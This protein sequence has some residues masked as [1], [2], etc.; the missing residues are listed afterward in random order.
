MEL[1]TTERAALRERVRKQAGYSHEAME[2]F[3]K[4]ATRKWTMKTGVRNKWVAA[5]RSG[6]FP[7]GNGELVTTRYGEEAKPVGYCCL[8]VL[9]ELDT[10]ARREGNTYYFPG[11][12]LHTTSIPPDYSQDRMGLHNEAQ[13]CLIALNDHGVSFANLA[14]VIEEYL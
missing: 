9:C 14:D 2:A 7:Q 5:L 8:G 6:H 4:L 1:P 12:L 13:D 3:D 10:Q 11:D